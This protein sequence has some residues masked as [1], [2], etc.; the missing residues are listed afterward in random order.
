MTSTFKMV[1]DRAQLARRLEALIEDNAEDT[2]RSMA[3]LFS[4]IPGTIPEQVWYEDE[5]LRQRLLARRVARLRRAMVDASRE[6]FASNRKLEALR[7]RR[8]ETVAKAYSE[9]V[10]IRRQARRLL[11]KKA[12]SVL[13]LRG[14]TRRKPRPLLRQIRTV[15]DCLSEPVTTIP[16]GSG[17]EVRLAIWMQTLEP[18]VEVLESSIEAVTRG[19]TGA[20]V[21]L[22]GKRQ[23]MGE[24]DQHF[25]RI[26]R[27]LK[28]TYQLVGLDELAAQVPP[29]EPR[30]SRRKTEVRPAR[31][32][33]SKA[34][35]D[36]G[37]LANVVDLGRWVKQRLLGL[38]AETRRR[39]VEI[40]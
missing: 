32:V 14:R 31:K 10:E 27:F 6:H 19:Q 38:G 23:A 2:A 5:L 1:D 29:S 17:L 26:G 4:A 30:Q 37:P 33:R 16:T 34:G 13:G 24:F 28:A 21:T 35:A 25:G 36:R 39:R 11:A 7:V 20:V 40:V 15:V 18:L 3:A 22:K 12:P 8:D 9:L